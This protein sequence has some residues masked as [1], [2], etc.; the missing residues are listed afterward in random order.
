MAHS[1]AATMQF[2][3]FGR[4]NGSGGGAHTSPSTLCAEGPTSVQAISW[5]IDHSQQRLGSLVVLLMIAN[6]AR[7]DGTG[8]WPSI[9]TL[10][11][12][13]R[14]SERQVQYCLRQLAKSGE[15]RVK[16]EAGPHGTNLYSIPGVQ[17]LHREGAKSYREGCNLASKAIPE[18][19]PN[20]SL[21][22]RKDKEGN[23]YVITPE[24]TRRYLGP[25]EIAELEGG[26]TK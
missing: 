20:P 19:A 23:L 2:W 5:V 25:R 18:T 15:L 22:V 10:A 9:A 3:R 11:K 13:A 7:S 26:C 12:E 1:G 8:A 14:M 4:S 6:H 16:R 17:I 24:R 21:T